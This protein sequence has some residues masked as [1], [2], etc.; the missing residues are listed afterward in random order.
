[1]SQLSGTSGTRK[2]AVK[3]LIVCGVTDVDHSWFFGNFLGFYRMLH[4]P[5]V[6]EDFK[7]S[8]P[9]REYFDENQSVKFG[10]KGS[11]DWT[12]MEVY[13]KD[14]WKNNQPFWTQYS[15]QRWDDLVPDVLTYLRQAALTMIKDDII[16]VILLGHGSARGTSLGNEYLS[17]D[18]LAAAFDR[19][20]SG[21]QVNL[22]VQSC[23]SGIFTDKIQ[24]ANQQ[25][26]YVHVSASAYQSSWADLRSPSGNY[27]NSVFSGA[28]LR[29]LGYAVDQSATA[30][31]LEGHIAFVAREG[32]DNPNDPT[33]KATP[34]NYTKLNITTPFLD[35]LF[36]QFVDR[37]FVTAPHIA[38]R[39]LSPPNLAAVS[40][41]A[42][43]PGLR[44]DAVEST[45]EALNQ[46]FDICT[47]G[48]S[49]SQDAGLRNGFSSNLYKFSH[50]MVNLQSYTT[51]LGR[52]LKTMK[53]R[54]RIQEHFW[55]AVEGLADNALVNLEDKQLCTRN[56]R[57]ESL[58]MWMENLVDM[59]GSFSFA[60]ECGL[61][62]SERHAGFFQPPLIWLAHIIGYASPNIA[63]V[64]SYL[65]T[66]KVLGDFNRE[67]FDTCGKLGADQWVK[68]WDAA[69]AI[70]Y[71]QI[72][73]WLP[74]DFND[75]NTIRRE[76]PQR[77]NT[78]V[79]FYENYFGKDTW[80]DSSLI[81]A[82]SCFTP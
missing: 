58:P 69:P 45:V 20:K 33:A 9:I 61:Q 42:P 32:K 5:G 13:T 19:F 35:V 52:T 60:K 73:F 38:R 78:L 76:F 70:K 8:Y 16:N 46:E 82:S 22:V 37:G 15:H 34:Q 74:Q 3:L 75:S 11:A 64:M 31:T 29:N 14:D 39:V 55:F 2:P 50:N 40:S 7:S 36:T 63:A 28:F 27:R 57:W 4:R 80:G 24:A 66:T 65:V 49:E 47:H 12:P 43:L 10:R 6:D 62:A 59:L 26:R 25:E 41:V 53:W 17:S 71:P 1:M 72:G 77:Y 21:V 54:F 18:Q 48:G 44:R 81:E 68:L 23:Q 56:M 51:M 30:R 79:I 67:H